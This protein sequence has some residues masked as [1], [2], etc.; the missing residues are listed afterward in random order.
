M[1]ELTQRWSV[2]GILVL[3]ALLFWL[4]YTQL[5]LFS[6]TQN[7]YYLHGIAQESSSRLANDFQA[8]VTDAWPVFTKL[9]QVTRIYGKDY[10]FSG[11]HF[12][13]TATYISSLLLISRQIVPKEISLVS[14]V[15]LAG[16]L[17]LIHSELMADITRYV[18]GTNIWFGTYAGVANQ[19][20][21]STVLQPAT[22]G[23]LIIASIAAA[24]KTRYYTAAI[25][26]GSAAMIHF[27][28]AIATAPLI[29]AYLL[30]ER[31][32]K[33]TL[34]EIALTASMWF[35][36]LIP[37]IT[38]TY[39]AFQQQGGN[40]TTTAQ[41]ILVAVRFPQHGDP[42]VWFGIDTVLQLAFAGIAVFLVRRTSL[43]LIL[44]VPSCFAIIL[45]MIHT[46]SGNQ[47]FGILM[48]W[49]L[50]AYIMPIALVVIVSRLSKY[51]DAAPR[52]L[53]LVLL[54]LV[55]V[56]SIYGTVTMQ[57]EWH[58]FGQ[59][60][61]E[62]RD[63]ISDAVLLPGAAVIVP[64]DLAYFRI[65]TGWPAVVDFKSHP[66]RDVEVLEWHQRLQLTQQFYNEPTN[67]PLIQK[68]KRRYRAQFIIFSKPSSTN[69]CPTLQPIAASE[70][71]AMLAL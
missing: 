71:F 62:L 19:A 49:R 16:M 17:V 66:W 34:R 57:Q 37:S 67:C 27:S 38:Y 44:A 42:R 48:P 10:W 7:F 13:L 33:Y 1:A 70:H 28:Y 25:L 21:I 39:T 36:L 26:A 32:Q 18:L 2:A 6:S 45:T 69:V 4:S 51:L 22:F 14:F 59:Q 40:I 15:S 54:L 61:Q 35:V 55:I 68:I 29:I 11:Y 20:V 31:Q 24:L 56:A 5:P 41:N 47:L 63:L 50:S 8:N 3:A 30:L 46:I 64:L 65:T 53:P 52:W 58:A 12:L 43:F 23:V 60:Q 9:V